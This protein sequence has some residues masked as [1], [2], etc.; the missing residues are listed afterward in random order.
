[1]L[2]KSDNNGI[3]LDSL[4]Q[5]V[6]YTLLEVLFMK[7]I[8]Y[9][10]VSV[11]AAFTLIFSGCGEKEVSVNALIDS[12]DGYT[13]DRVQVTGELSGGFITETGGVVIKLTGDDRR[14]DNSI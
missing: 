11:V 5:C 1:M 6:I 3:F 4:V 13:G 14:E 7:K 9:S 8:A 10:I 12:N 2:S